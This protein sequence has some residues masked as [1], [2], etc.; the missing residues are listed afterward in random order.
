MAC[1]IKVLFMKRLTL[2]CFWRIELSRMMNETYHY[3]DKRT[4]QQS[5]IRRMPLSFVEQKRV[6][7]TG[8]YD[9]KNQIPIANH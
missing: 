8:T 4:Q 1:F 6:F 7:K 5:G 3:E 2:L 9:F